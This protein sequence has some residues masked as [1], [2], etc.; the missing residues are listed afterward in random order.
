M[1][2]SFYLSKIKAQLKK[3]G[4]QLNTKQVQLHL[5]WQL[6]LHACLESKRFI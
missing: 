5:T 2:L 4:K 6:R 1:L 3:S